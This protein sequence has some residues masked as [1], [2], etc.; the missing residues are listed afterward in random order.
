MVPLNTKEVVVG[1]DKQRSLQWEQII[2]RALGPQYIPIVQKT[3]VGCYIVMF[4]KRE[5]K[6]KIK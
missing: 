4:A 5:H 2:Q 6:Q 3:M 1:K